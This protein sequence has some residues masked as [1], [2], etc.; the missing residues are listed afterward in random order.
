MSEHHDSQDS[1]AYR[2]SLTMLLWQLADDDL[3]V[4][5]RASEWLGLASHVE[6]DVAFSSIAQDEMGHAAMYYEL[7]EH[8]GYGSR[9]DL[10][11]LRASED[12]R[13]SVLLEIPNGPGSYLND[14]HFD[15]AFTIV[16][17]YLYDVWEMLRL[18]ALVA[19]SFRPLA[20]VAEKALGEKTYHLAHQ[21]LWIRKM[22][23]HSQATR[24]RLEQ[25]LAAAARYAGDLT[26]IEPWQAE[27]ERLLILPEASVLPT[28]WI[29]QVASF[30]EGQGF[31]VPAVGVPFNGRLGQHSPHLPELLATLSEVYRMDPKA[32]W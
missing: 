12:R 4:A 5:F 2:Q 10:S 9:D 20:Q 3:M 18:K 31:G 32:T 23:D 26:Y 15:W 13:N 17:H 21:E 8:L 19:S 30:L 7:L 16:R 24:Q 14:P 6:E 29:G 25:A 22:A 11:Q 27:W 1:K 28:Q